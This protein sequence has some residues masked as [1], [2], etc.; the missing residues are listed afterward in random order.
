MKYRAI[1][2]AWFSTLLLKALGEG[3]GNEEPRGAQRLL[4][5]APNL[6]SVPVGGMKRMR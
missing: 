1:A 3:R 6:E 2:A 4:K 5:C